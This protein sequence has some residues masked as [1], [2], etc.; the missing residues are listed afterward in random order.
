MKNVVINNSDPKHFGYVN[1]LRGYA[2]LGVLLGH[3]AQ[4]CHLSEFVYRGWMIEGLGNGVYLFFVASSFTLF[5]SMSKRMLIENNYLKNFFIRRF[6]RIAPLYWYGII[7]Y[8]LIYGN[9]TRGWLP[10]PSGLWHYLLNIFFLH[11][12]HPDTMSSVVPGGWSIGV[13]ML[14]YLILPTLFFY[15]SNAKRALGFTICAII[16]ANIVNKFS[17]MAFAGF[18]SQYSDPRLLDMFWFR[19]LPNQ[20]GC[21]SFGILLFFLLENKNI[22]SH[23][24]QKINNLGLLFLAIFLFVINLRYNLFHPA[25]W[26][27]GFSFI[28]MLFAL[29]LATKENV[30][31]VNKAINF[32]GEI[33]YSAYINHFLAI[34][35]VKKYFKFNFLN[36][37]S[38]YNFCLFVIMALVA[39]AITVVLSYCTY[40][41]VECPGRD[42]GKELIR[43]SG[44]LA[45]PVPE[46]LN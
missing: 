38:I 40:K 39:L 3:L 23:L 8:F 31:F 37:N 6:F 16:I 18:L 5:Y 27:I 13:E 14:F 29:S 41:L 26:H 22:V 36:G 32:I 44:R 35:L 12:L 43:R 10:G 45:R 42:L 25:P 4:S 33:S 9:E 1:A 7:V 19:W 24:Q 20:I 15:V 46:L 11:G 2:V 28:F 17:Q 30:L 34:A 21:F